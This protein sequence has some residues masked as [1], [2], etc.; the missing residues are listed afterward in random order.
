ML[1]ETQ[2]VKKHGMAGVFQQVHLYASLHIGR[3]RIDG[4]A[5]MLYRH[6]HAEEEGF[7]RRTRRF[8][9]LP[10]IYTGPETPV[11]RLHIDRQGVAQFHPAVTG[12]P[13][14]GGDCL[15]LFCEEENCVMMAQEQ[16][17]LCRVRDGMTFQCPLNNTWHFFE[18]I[19]A[20]LS[21][22]GNPK[23][24][25]FASL[26]YF[27]PTK[28]SNHNTLAITKLE[29]GQHEWHQK[30]LQMQ[31][32]YQQQA[33]QAQAFTQ[34]QVVQAENIVPQQA[35]PTPISLQHQGMQTPNQVQQHQEMA[36]IHDF[37][38]MMANQ[39]LEFDAAANMAP[40]LFVPANHNPFLPLNDNWFGLPELEPFIDDNLLN[41]NPVIDNALPELTLG[42]EYMG[43]GFEPQAPAFLPVWND[44]TNAAMWTEV[45]ALPDLANV[46]VTMPPQM[47]DMGVDPQW[48]QY[49]NQTPTP[50][51]YAD[52]V[53]VLDLRPAPEPVVEG[54]SGESIFAITPM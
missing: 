32:R 12:T 24:L 36:V 31:Y 45:T 14:R 53:D 10:A 21:P 13:S 28:G 41:I 44:M 47:E 33:I 23:E 43:H 52:P 11:E 4:E 46:D 25:I 27:D 34:Q 17:M 51:M 15:L 16:Q 22:E 37:E 40:E 50:E 7:V 42:S 29:S 38:A 1:T 5:A 30:A 2:L 6:V 54:D 35:M 3:E 18:G 39:L 9:W 48:L 19:L 8:A 26:D 20:I 49:L